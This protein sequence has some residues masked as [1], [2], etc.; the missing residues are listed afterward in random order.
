MKR[1]YLLWLWF[2][3]S[4]PCMLHAQQLVHMKKLW[5]R[6]Q[7]H[8]ICGDYTIHLRIRDINKALTFLPKTDQ[9][10]FGS[11]SGLDT[12][13]NYV[14]ELVPG[15]RKMEYK[16]KLQPLLQN[17]VGAYLLTSGHAYVE[18]KHKHLKSIEVRMGPAMDFNHRYVVPVNIYEPKTDNIIFSGIM[19]ADLY[20]KDLGFDD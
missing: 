12:N 13:L 2:A 9:L 17:A 5:S 18:R 7:V 1:Y 20:H 10:E 6:P 16:N 4:L 8:L 19:N 14:V 11:S 15:N 3:L